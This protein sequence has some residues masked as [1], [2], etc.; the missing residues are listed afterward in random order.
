MGM[1]I[2]DQ[3]TDVTSQG[4]YANRHQN[5]VY[6]GQHDGTAHVKQELIFDGPGLLKAQA[7]YIQAQIQYVKGG[8][9]EYGMMIN[10][11]QDYIFAQNKVLE[12]IG[13]FR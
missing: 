11:Q 8:S 4:D 9:S 2:E 3:A 13:V 5:S 1:P 6:N 12:Q 7:V 10:A